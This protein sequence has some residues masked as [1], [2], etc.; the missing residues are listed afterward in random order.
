[1]FL[2]SGIV[3]ITDLTHQD[4]IQ[5]DI[6]K[7]TI[8]RFKEHKSLLSIEEDASQ[9]IIEARLWDPIWGGIVIH[10]IILPQ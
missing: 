6:I 1:M 10:R 7:S 2:Q 9:K 3:V 5:P 4:D 8:E